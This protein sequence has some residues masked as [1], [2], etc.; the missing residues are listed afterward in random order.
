[1]NRRHLPMVPPMAGRGAGGSAQDI[2]A[3]QR[4]KAE[5]L[6]ASADRYQRGA[7]GEKAVAEILRGLPPLFTVLHDLQVPDSKANIDHLVIGPSGV[8]VVD[9]KHWS[10]PLRVGDGMVFRGRYPIRKELDTV[11][12]EAGRAAAV[13]GVPVHPVLCFVGSMLPTRTI[14]LPP[15]RVT[16]GEHLVAGLLAGKA[17]YDI[18]DISRLT[19]LAQRHL[20]PA[21]DAKTVTNG[22]TPRTTPRRGRRPTTA[23]TTS[24][25]MPQNGRLGKA[26]RA[27][28]TKVP[29]P[30][31]LL[32]V[33]G[34]LLAGAPTL[35]RWAGDAAPGLV[36]R[37]LPESPAAEAT[38]PS[39]AETPSVN[40]DF[41]CP[42]PGAGWT[43]TLHWPG[44]GAPG[45]YELA[46]SA[47]QVAWTPFATW[48]A[49]AER[50]P[51]IANLGAD[52]AVIVRAR[53]AG[54]D[55][56]PAGDGTF[57]SPP[58]LC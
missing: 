44:D 57:R 48:T 7:D 15:V 46:T 45:G 40:G 49:S 14:D 41:S 51:T 28:K 39:P 19:L 16:T 5:R 10:Q 30:L 6:L 13:L 54:D 12:W 27:R 24:T 2:A 50:A 38:P 53:A 11:A 32:A 26:R 4:A 9:A 56:A 42:V 37:L 23:A 33:A 55:R 31:L 36:E 43:L 34:A 58:H 17:G 20:P 35:S 3:R 21:G 25:S 47:D 18:N 22:P 29:E 52:T 8:F 1:M